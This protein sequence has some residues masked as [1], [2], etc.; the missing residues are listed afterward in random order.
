MK[1]HF[2]DGVEK[3][4]QG[5]K[6]LVWLVPALLL[7]GGGYILLT[8]L[9]PSLINV[10]LLESGNTEATEE[11]LKAKPGSYG[12]RLFIPQIGVD[13]AVLIGDQSVLEKGA[14]HRQPE[15]G[16]PITGGNF[17][18]SAHRF[19]MGLT[20]QQTRA[21][22]PFYNISKLEVGDQL[23]V[24]Y[25]GERYGYEVNKKYAVKPNQ[26]EIEAPSDEPK[27]TLYSCT[28]EGSADG[29][30]VLE[31]KPLGKVEKLQ[32]SQS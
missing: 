12:D 1:Y 22:S 13:V 2:I 3:K 15:N 25:K 18:L 8:A 31:A 9:S 16:D 21:K 5:W 24:D 28:L 23:F 11:R 29:R 19:E 14:W 32:V 17:V 30:D 10:P 26:V 6:P 27:M 4:R 7:M 20:P